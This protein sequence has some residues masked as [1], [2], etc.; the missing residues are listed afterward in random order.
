MIPETETEISDGA[1][2]S[3]KKLKEID[4]PDSVACFGEGVFEECDKLEKITY[5]GIT[6]NSVEDF[7]SSNI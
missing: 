1:F 5:R 6:Y 7:E 4:I 3:C 2:E